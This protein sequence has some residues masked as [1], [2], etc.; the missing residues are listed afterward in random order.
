[1][2]SSASPKRKPTPTYV[3]TGMPRDFLAVTARTG[4]VRSSIAAM[5]AGTTSVDAAW[6]PY[7]WC[8]VR[9]ISELSA[10]AAASEDDAAEAAGGMVAGA[11]TTV[12][13]AP[14]LRS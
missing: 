12:L 9:L 1:M 10:A 8:V 4:E 3:Q 5:R 11:G 6:P 7:P 14:V 2:P 13:R